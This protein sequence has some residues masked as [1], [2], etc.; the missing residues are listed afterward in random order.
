MRQIDDKRAF[1]RALSDVVSKAFNKPAAS[2]CIDVVFNADLY[3]G[4]AFEP[5]VILHCVRG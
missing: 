3:F 1:I 2:I 4:G 5:G